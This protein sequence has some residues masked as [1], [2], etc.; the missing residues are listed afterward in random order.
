MARANTLVLSKCHLGQPL[1][2][3]VTIVTKGPVFRATLHNRMA[4]CFGKH[5]G[6]HIHDPKATVNSFLT[7]VGISSDFAI[8]FC[9][10]PIP[11]KWYCPPFPNLYSCSEHNSHL[12]SWYKAMFPSLLLQLLSPNN[13]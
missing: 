7:G 5:S 11:I 1:T 8:K 3:L 2:C 9:P 6:N 4:Y 13:H 12:A 10:C